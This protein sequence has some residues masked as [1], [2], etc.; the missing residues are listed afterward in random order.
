MSFCAACSDSQISRNIFWIY[1]ICSI[2]PSFYLS[3]FFF[4]F[5]PNVGCNCQV[6]R[7]C[8]KIHW[9]RVMRLSDTK[10]WFCA[11]FIPWAIILWKEWFTATLMTSLLD[12]L[13]SAVHCLAEL[14]HY[15][16]LCTVSMKAITKNVTILHTLIHETRTKHQILWLFVINREVWINL[17][18]TWVIHQFWKEDYGHFKW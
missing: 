5:I 10:W 18:Y 4:Y 14:V 3:F 8:N 12:A 17:H 6:K 16:T 9:Q 13:Q 2:L 11:L 7:C 1:V 15:F